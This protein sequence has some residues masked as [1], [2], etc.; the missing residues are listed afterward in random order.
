MKV[1]TTAIPNN[2][3][4]RGRPFKYPFD[5]LNPGQR[6]TMKIIK[7]AKK[8]RQ[9]LVQACYQYKKSNSL[10]WVTASLIEGDSIVL[11]RVS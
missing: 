6:I 3:K 5:K 11:Y 4:L 10:K 7:D 2:L 9:K 8:E 1:E